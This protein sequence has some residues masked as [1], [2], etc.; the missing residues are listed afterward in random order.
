MKKSIILLIF[1]F[2]IISCRT[3]E[4]LNQVEEEYI[5]DE[6]VI[7]SEIEQNVLEDENEYVEERVSVQYVY[8]EKPIYYP[9]NERQNNS[10][11]N[12]TVVPD[13]NNQ[14]EMIYDYDPSFVYQ[15][16]CQPLMITDIRLQPGEELI[17]TPLLG[18]SQRWEIMGTVSYEE[19]QQVTHIC[20][21]P[22][23]SG[24][25]TS[26]FI[27]TTRRSYNLVLKSFENRRTPAVSWRY[28]L[29]NNGFDEI[30]RNLSQ[31]TDSLDNIY[32]SHDYRIRVP[33]RNRPIWTPEYVYDD[34]RKTYIEFS[35]TAL[36]HNLP[37]ARGRDG[38]MFNQRVNGNIL[39][40]DGLIERAELVHEN[41][42]VII[43]KEGS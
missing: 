26:M 11:Y 39:E 29:S 43:I 25:E 4:E 41:V 36:H 17:G 8:I 6:E 14:G 19:G 3:T 12:E 30:I 23:T 32:M 34:G 9:E 31:E 38:E 18:D 21:K 35:Q 13:D 33:R 7:D 37:V 40:I 22:W 10:F 1:L 2:T 27:A 20:I 5:E 42:K 28:P 24:L 16:Y 15:V